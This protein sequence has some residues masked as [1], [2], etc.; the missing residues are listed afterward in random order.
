MILIG[1][2]LSPFV[3]RVA[4]ALQT[5]G[6]AYRHEP[7][8][9]IPD[10]DRIVPLNPLGRVPVLVLD[11]GETLFE[12]GAILDYLDELAGPEKA[13]IAASGP[14]RWAALRICALATG[15]CEKLVSLIYERRNHEIVSEDYIARCEGQVE[16]AIA[17]LD[18][19]RA[20]RSTQFWFGDRI[21]HAD[22]AVT[23]AVTFLGKAQPEL[24][25]R[26]AWPAL[27]EHAGRCEELPAFRAVFPA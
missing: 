20:G 6:I 16:R 26:H 2:Y 13:L 21:T 18:A 1:Q 15:A 27:A 4:V 19:D 11:S 7:W 10:R 9:T 17:A 3:R 5:Y 23:C 25:A 12:S 22:I 8:S 14:D 24:A